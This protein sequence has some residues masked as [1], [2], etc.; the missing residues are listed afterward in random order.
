[1]S[2]GLKVIVVRSG[3]LGP[4]EKGENCVKACGP[5]SVFV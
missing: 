5:I 2:F 4:G 3:S 1:M